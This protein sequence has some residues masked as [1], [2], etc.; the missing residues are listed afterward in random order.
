MKATATLRKFLDA[1]T[2]DWNTGRILIQKECAG[3]YS[4]KANPRYI[5][6][7]DPILDLPFDNGYGSVGCPAFIA[8]DQDAIYVLAVYD[9]ASWCSK[10][11]KSLSR[12]LDPNCET[13]CIGGG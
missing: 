3:S 8:E 13:P 9:G 10:I 1:C 12:Y 2:F 6:R 4:E 7:T 11:Y 5:Q